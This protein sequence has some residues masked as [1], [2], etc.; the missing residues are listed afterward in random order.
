MG[1]NMYDSAYGDGLEIPDDELEN[2]WK[3]GS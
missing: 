2:L 1:W 3:K